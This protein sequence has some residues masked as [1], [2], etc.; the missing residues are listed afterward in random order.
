V[1]FR[2]TR[3]VSAA[4]TRTVKHRLEP[5]ASNKTNFPHCG[6]FLRK[7]GSSAVGVFIEMKFSVTQS[8]QEVLQKRIMSSVTPDTSIYE[9]IGECLVWSK[10]KLKAGYGKIKWK[11][12]TVLAHR[13][14]YSAFN[15]PI[16]DELCVCHKCD[17]PSCVNP[18]HLFLGTYLENNLDK[19][20]KGRS[21]SGSNHGSKT[22]PE[23]FARGERA[24]NV[25]LTEV[26]VKEIRRFDNLGWL[27][28]DIA[29]HFNVKRATVSHIVTRR[30][31][32]HVA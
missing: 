32:K 29:A 7:L 27:Q 11:R 8:E 26:E 20:E 2:L 28:E 17:N 16:P 15:G 21:A 19:K 22:K 9:G 12:K 1:R 3:W 5:D 14:S 31:W 24:G 18:E 6:E 25:K 13:A 30:N 23:R 10:G 4:T